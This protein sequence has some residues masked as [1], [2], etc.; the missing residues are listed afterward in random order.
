MSSNS[1]DMI[2]CVYGA[3]NGEPHGESVMDASDGERDPSVEITEALL[4]V[5]K[6]GQFHQRILVLACGRANCLSPS[7]DV[8][9]P[10][11]VG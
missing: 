11:R 1:V 2:N 8:E 4:I 7:F 3:G 10:V 9:K 6:R 5:L